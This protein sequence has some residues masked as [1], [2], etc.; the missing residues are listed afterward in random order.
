MIKKIRSY[1]YQKAANRYLQNTTEQKLLKQSEVAALKAF[2]AAEENTPFY[3]KIIQQHNI[4]TNQISSIS[5]FKSNIPVISK[6]ETFIEY[7]DNIPGLCSKQGL[8]DVGAILSSSGT[9]GHFS[10]GLLTRKDLEEGPDFVDFALNQ[11]FGIFDKKTLLINCLPMGVRVPSNHCVVADVSVRKDMALS[12]VRGLGN[13]FDLIIMVG[14]NS[15]VKEVL[16]FGI[17]AGIDWQK[18]SIRIVIGEEGFPENFRSYLFCLLGYAKND[19]DKL[20]VGSSMGISELGLTVFQENKNTI[21]LRRFIDQNEIFREELFGHQCQICPMLFVYYPMMIY[22]EEQ[23]ENYQNSGFG[24]NLIFT[25]LDNKSTIPLIRYLSG[26]RGQIVLHSQISTML[27]KHGRKDLI[28]QYRL[29]LVAVFERGNTVETSDGNAISTEAI[30]AGIYTDHNLASKFTGY[31]KINYSNNGVVLIEI[32]LK[33]EVAHSDELLKGFQKAV[34]LYHSGDIEIKLYP[35]E[36][37]PYSLDYER[38]FRYI[39]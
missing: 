12:L 26:D 29:P 23:E 8:K 17:T 31:F 5:D 19:E 30:K 24:K 22:L 32:Q 10:Y 28:P 21:P 38:K 35:F 18:Y 13:K 2:H 36:K 33:E 14:E 39:D 3:K 11:N 6:K 16:E 1:L 37:F 27:E 25:K 34:R 20:I 15:F 4:S 9:T 7:K